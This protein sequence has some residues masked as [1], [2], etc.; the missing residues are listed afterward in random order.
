[1]RAFLLAALGLLLASCASVSMDVPDDFL[2]LTSQ[3]SD[4]VRAVTA[5]GA[6]I[7]VREFDVNDDASLS[8]WTEALTNDL[9]ERRGYRLEEPQTVSGAGGLEGVLLEGGCT[10]DG[11]EQGYLVAVFLVPGSLFSSDR[12]RTV[13]FTAE[14]ALFDQH[15]EAVREA[16]ATVR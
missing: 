1:M 3:E 6:R 2:R 11:Q 12:V 8:F 4:D 5:D 7:W 15:E 16:I 9:V 14:R 13:E 10:V